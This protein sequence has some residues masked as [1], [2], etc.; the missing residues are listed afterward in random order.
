MGGRGTRGEGTILIRGWSI[1]GYV[2]IRVYEWPRTVFMAAEDR[3]IRV[4]NLINI[5]KELI[6]DKGTS[7]R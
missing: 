7:N 6:H 1:L 4:A 5:S 2:G 3:G